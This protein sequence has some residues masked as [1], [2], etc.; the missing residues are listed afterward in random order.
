M[1]RTRFRVGV[2]IVVL[3]GTF[4]G[5][6][7][8]GCGATST[9]STVAPQVRATATPAPVVLVKVKTVTLG[10]KHVQVLA[11]LQGKTLYYF[12]PDTST[13]AV[14]TDSCTQL[15]PPLTVQS[16]VPS[17]SSPLPGHLSILAASAMSQVTYNGHPLYTYAKDEDAGDAYGQGVEG[18][19]FVATPELSVQSSGS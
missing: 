6:A 18:E 5:L 9:A 12:K 3:C 14:C 15:W 2:C 19:W 4:I 8:A 7:L 1:V 17:S 10:R 16:G 11:N 13:T